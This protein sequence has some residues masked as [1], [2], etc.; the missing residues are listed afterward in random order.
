M[1][2]PTVDEDAYNWLMEN[3]TNLDSNLQTYITDS[4]A[5]EDRPLAME[6]INREIQDITINDIRKTFSGNT[7]EYNVYI[8][9]NLLKTLNASVLMVAILKGAFGTGDL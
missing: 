5:E 7:Y 3:S 9:V 4:F 6:G 8:A 1:Y 2:I